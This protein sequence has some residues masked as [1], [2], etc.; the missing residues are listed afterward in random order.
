[1]RGLRPPIVV[2]FL[3]FRVNL[4]TFNLNVYFKCSTKP[5]GLAIFLY[6]NH[7]PFFRNEPDKDGAA[8]YQL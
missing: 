5:L 6:F 2:N 8:G 7:Y 1:M 3:D 4:Y